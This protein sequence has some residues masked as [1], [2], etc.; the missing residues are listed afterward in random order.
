MIRHPEIQRHAQASIDDV[1]KGRL[2]DFSDYDSLPYVHAIVKECLRW[3]PVSPLSMQYYC[4]H[5]K[6]IL[7]LDTL[8]DL[9]HRLS[10]DDVYKG[11]HIPEGSMVVVNHWWV[12]GIF[13]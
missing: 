1:C 9:P 6:D 2:P 11:Y 8:I 5:W 10:K 3:H 13:Y 4:N 7:T 12:V